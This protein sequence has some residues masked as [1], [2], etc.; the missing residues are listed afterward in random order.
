MI[1]TLQLLFV[2]FLVAQTY[3]HRKARG[4]ICY[5]LIVVQSNTTADWNVDMPF[6]SDKLCQSIWE[7]EG[8]SRAEYIWGYKGSA[9]AS[10]PPPP[11]QKK[12]IIHK[13]NTLS[14]AEVFFVLPRARLLAHASLP[15]FLNFSRKKTKSQQRLRKGNIKRGV[16]ARKGGAS[17]SFCNLLCVLFILSAKVTLFTAI[18]HVYRLALCRLGVQS[19]SWPTNTIS[20][21]RGCMQNAISK[22][23]VGRGLVMA[24]L[25]I[26]SLV[27]SLTSMIYASL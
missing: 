9:Q 11:P 20:T 12:N 22:S 18:Y 19:C 2:I 4:C 14:S 8:L 6:T 23:V 1:F 25:N 17:S 5:T 7:E 3:Q 24:C 26:N 15:D 13:S 10:P 21:G 16:I 27:S